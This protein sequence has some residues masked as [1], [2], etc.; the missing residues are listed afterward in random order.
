M[1]N[2]LDIS[3]L[4]KAAKAFDN[5]LVFALKVEEKTAETQEFYEKEIAR[6]AVIQH[7]EF[8]YELCWKTMKRYIEMD[9]GAE[10]DILTRK[11]LSRLSAERRLITSFDQWVEFH[12][13]RNKTSHVYD[14]EVADEVY[15][16]A[17]TFTNSLK[18]FIL[19]IEGRI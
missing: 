2:K 18:E 8:T 11:D 9:I 10:A 17:K 15:E 19:T 5:A 1:E 13:A 7:F 16:I 6:A 4:K 14:E 12:Q 3:A